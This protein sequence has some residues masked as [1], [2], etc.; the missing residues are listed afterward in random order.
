MDEIDKVDLDEGGS[1][2]AFLEAKEGRW[3]VAEM[4]RE[5]E[6]L[7]VKTRLADWQQ[8]RVTVFHRI[9]LIFT[10]YLDNRI[11]LISLD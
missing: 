5:P 8:G 9:I 2:I 3:S 4:W 11:H 7:E 1:Q 10:S 6:Q